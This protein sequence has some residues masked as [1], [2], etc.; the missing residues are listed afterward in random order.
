MVR[1]MLFA[2]R[3]RRHPTI[4][5]R[6]FS[7]ASASVRPCDIQPGIAGH[8]ATI[9]PVSSGSSVTSSFILESYQLHSDN[10]DGRRGSGYMR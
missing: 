10:S 3:A 4:A 5:S 2:D 7:S 1:G 6:M 8:S 9:M